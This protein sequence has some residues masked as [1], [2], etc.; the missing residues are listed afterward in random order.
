M[1]LNR[2][3][4]LLVEPPAVATGDIAFNLIVFFLVCASTAPD[5]GRKQTIPRSEA[6]ADKKQQSENIEVALSRT[7]ASIN[8]SPVRL[9]DFKGRLRTMMKNKPRQ[10][11]RIV[12]VKSTPDTPYDHWINVTGMI[13]EAG[14]V[15][16]LQIEEE[17]SVTV[18]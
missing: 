1:R 18:Q 9:A 7:S 2:S 4:K 3:T 12:V 6:K 14:G 17:K 10:E 15:I 8:G 5:A 11:D 16:T 13:E